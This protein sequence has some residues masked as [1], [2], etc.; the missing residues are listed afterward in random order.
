MAKLFFP[1]GLFYKE[2]MQKRWLALLAFV[3][4]CPSVFFQTLTPLTQPHRNVTVTAFARNGKIVMQTTNVVTANFDGFVNQVVGHFSAGGWATI[5]IAGIAL[6]SLWVERNHE[7]GWFTFSGPVTKG[8]VLRAKYVFDL[9]LILALFTTLA[10][11]LGIVDAAI[12]VHYPIGGIVRWWIAEL[13]IQTSMYGLA[14]LV[15]TLVGNLVLAAL[16]TFGIANIPMYAGIPLIHWL[17]ANW[18]VFAEPSKHAAIPFSWNMMWAITHLSPLNW[19]SVPLNEPGTSAWTSPWPY[20]VWFLVFTAVACAVSERLYERTPNERLSD[21]LAFRW[22][23][24]PF[25]VALSGLLAGIVVKLMGGT[26]RF[27]FTG[28]VL[29]LIVVWA[30][31]F[32]VSQQVSKRF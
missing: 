4:A 18:V 9:A 20:F 28:V 27:T 24:H 11:I 25:I 14:L 6:Y 16:L 13:A 22:L 10:I 32:S 7:V 5:V 31:I 12:G 26:G 23:K 17:G 30:A 21:L 3:V 2:W 29:V 15:A 19:F 8:Q 1:K